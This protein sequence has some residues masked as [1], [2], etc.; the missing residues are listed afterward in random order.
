MIR[1]F[2]EC[3][4]FD[5]RSDLASYGFQF[6]G[7]IDGLELGRERLED[8]N[9][10]CE[11]SDFCEESTLQPDESLSTTVYQHL[12]FTKDTALH[13]PLSFQQLFSALSL[14]TPCILGLSPLPH[15]LRP[16]FSSTLSYE[17]PMPCFIRGRSDIARSVFK[18]FKLRRRIRPDLIPVWIFSPTSRGVSMVVRP[19]PLSTSTIQFRYSLRRSISVIT[20]SLNASH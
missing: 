18:C 7:K 11:K 19:A 14:S 4:S 3:A 5:V 17:D 20:A 8:R 10:L 13:R 9:Q 1:G 2:A 6:G 16:F 15:P 12:S